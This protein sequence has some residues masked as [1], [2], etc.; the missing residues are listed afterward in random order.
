MGNLKFPL[1]YN[2]VLNLSYCT[3]LYIKNIYKLRFISYL[4]TYRQ[5]KKAAF[6]KSAIII[7]IYYN[8]L[9]L[10]NQFELIF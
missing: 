4:N 9:Q 1:G 5:S 10:I 6:V 7:R 2:H 8:T 3:L